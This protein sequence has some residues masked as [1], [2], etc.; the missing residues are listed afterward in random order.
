MHNFIGGYTCY[1]VMCCYNFQGKH[2]MKHRRV[3]N[4]GGGCY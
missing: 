3:R 4:E 2:Q 1:L